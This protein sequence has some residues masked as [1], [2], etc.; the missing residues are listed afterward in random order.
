M[1]N[2]FHPNGTFVRVM[3]RLYDLIVLNVLLSVLYLTVVL[4]GPAAVSVY[5]VLFRRV[6]DE[7]GVSTVGDFLRSI[8][9]NVVLAFPA[10]LLMFVDVMILAIVLRYL[11][12]ETQLFSP[13][14]WMALALVGLLLTAV[15]SYLFPLLGRYR[16]TFGRHLKN[17]C[18]LAIRCPKT[19]LLLLCVNLMPLLCI[20]A[21]PQALHFWLGIWLLIGFSGGAYINA[22]ALKPVFERVTTQKKSVGGEP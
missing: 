16:N 17:A 9:E 7:D 8:R 12:E 14:I 4:S 5:Q 1:K 6:R 19:T 18:I 2:L 10:T 3:T 13:V 22:Q 21:F 15:L 20:A 11:F